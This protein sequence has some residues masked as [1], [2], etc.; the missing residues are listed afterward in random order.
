MRIPSVCSPHSA[1]R[2]TRV[3]SIGK[4]RTGRVSMYRTLPPVPLRPSRC[5]INS[6]RAVLPVHLLPSCVRECSQS[7]CL[8]LGRI[9]AKSVAPSVFRAVFS[10][11]KVTAKTSRSRVHPHTASWSSRATALAACPPLFLPLTSLAF[12]TPFRVSTLPAWFTTCSHRLDHFSQPR[13]CPSIDRMCRRHSPLS[14]S[15]RECCC[16]IPTPFPCAFSTAL[17]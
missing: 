17:S 5:S 6:P 14:A 11:R 10:L 7:P 8:G 4:R 16:R 2:T 12:A 1:R 13:L 15:D 3:S 9:S